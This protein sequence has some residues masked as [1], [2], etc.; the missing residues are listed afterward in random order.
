MLVRVAHGWGTGFEGMVPHAYLALALEGTAAIR[1]HVKVSIHAVNVATDV[2]SRNVSFSET[3]FTPLTGP[4]LLVVLDRLGRL[5]PEGLEPLLGI[6]GRQRM[7]VFDVTEEDVRFG[8]RL[9]AEKSCRYQGDENRGDLA[10]SVGTSLKNEDAQSFATTRRRCRECEIPDERLACS[11]F[12]H[13]RVFHRPES[14]AVEL[15]RAQC[16]LGREEV[17]KTPSA[18]RP[19]GNECWVRGFEFEAPPEEAW[20]A[21]RL[22]EALELLDA[23]WAAVFRDHLLVLRGRRSVAAGKLATSCAT[24]A[25]LEAHLSALADLTKGFEVGDKILKDEHRGHDNYKPGMS[26]ARVDSALEKALAHDA[27]AFGR[28]RRA[29]GVLRD[30]TKLRNAMQHSGD[31]VQAYARFQLPYPPPSP[32]ETWNRVQSRVAGALREVA[33]EL[34]DLRDS[35]L[36]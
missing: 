7:Y 15:R 27:D 17:E 26:L 21:L 34:A 2:I 22:H 30:A 13:A 29:V 12:C 24:A 8:L 36:G 20:Y 4:V 1:M 25:E 5:G 23:R 35:A 3:D 9:A 33:D 31:I 11:N 16:Q 19:G 28:A 18:C 6:V 32:Q 10:C 14:L